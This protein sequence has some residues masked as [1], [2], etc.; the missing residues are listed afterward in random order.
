MTELTRQQLE[1][2]PYRIHGDIGYALHRFGNYLAERE[3]Y[4]DTEL[5]GLDAVHFYLVQKHSWFPHQVRAMTYIDLTFVL[6]EEMMTWREEV[7]RKG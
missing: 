5:Q 6:T 1:E 3:G 2:L 7:S 4:Q